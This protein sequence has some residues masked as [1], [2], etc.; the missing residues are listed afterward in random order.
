MPMSFSLAYGTEGAN[1]LKII[2][3]SVPNVDVPHARV[4]IPEIQKLVPC[5]GGAH[6]NQKGNKLW[7]A[8]LPVPCQPLF[9]KFL[10]FG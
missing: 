8:D 10:I 5:G 9:I 2:I 3:A 7:G 6:G 4:H 1:T